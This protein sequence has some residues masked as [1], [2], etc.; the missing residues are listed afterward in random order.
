MK[1]GRRLWNYA[2]QYKKLLIWAVV[3]LIIA[4]GTELTGP[5]IGK[6]MID[7]H[8]L[9]IEKT[10]VKASADDPGA[11]RFRGH[12]YVR[13]DRLKPGADKTGEAHIY[14]VGA[15][16][17]FVDRPV[18]FD[19]NRSVSDGRLTISNG[20]ESRSYPAITLSRQE[21]FQFYRP[22][23]KGL[24]TLTAIYAGLLMFSVCF[25]YGQH[26]LLQM[27]ANRII[28]RMRQDVFSHIQKM[29]IRYFDNLPVGK[30][31]ARITN[32]TEAV[33]DLYVT[34]LSTFITSGV[35]M[36]GIF[37]ALFMLDVRL[38]AVCL[39]IIPILMIWSV[40]YRKY[41]SVFNQNIRSINSDINA[42]MNESIQGMPIIQAF[43]RE[44]ETMKEFEELNEAHFRYKNK[45]LSLNSLMS[46][47]LVN[48]LRNLAF[49][50]LIWY[51]GGASLSAAGIVS[52]GVLYAFVD[53]LNRLFQPVTGIVN[54]FSKLELARVSAARVF[55]L[56][57]EEG[58]EEEGA[59][60][61]RKAEGTVEFR[62]VSF[63]YRKGEEVLKHIS[64][65][66]E[67]GE[68]VALVGHTG[69]GKSSILNL[70]FRFYDAQKGDIL[71]DDKSIYGMSRQELRSH[72]GIVLQDPYL[73]SGTIGSNVTLDD[74]RISLEQAEEA[75]R[76]VGAASLLQSLPK[77]I[78]EPVTEKGGT[79]SSGQRQ[80]ISFARALV[81]DPAILI[82]DEATAHIDTET[83]A[84][85]QKALQVVQEGRTTFI[86]A[87]RLSTIRHA[88]Q[89]L[90][91][92]KGRIIEKGS[93]DELMAQKGQYHQMYELQKGT[94]KSA[95]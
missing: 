25:H 46:H 4:V 49:V 51:F 18:S 38:A 82:L 84:V 70:L 14:Q 86:I 13:E 8:I 30:V 35:Y 29:P 67:K 91:L 9:G 57:Q 90:V 16:Y 89:I 88:D 83:E 79:L 56:L 22:E 92:E 1:T 44:K 39:L 58:T 81:F 27:G 63:G 43:R 23:I 21:I 68:T 78:R 37:T 7:D 93:H 47:S 24:L 3:L 5:F 2:L 74:Q 11:V 60:A 69:S 52:I 95:V 53:Y 80:L 12:D 73:F 61:D 87:H 34:V 59:P 62:D 32:D 65:T 20:K 72:M 50:G 85:I 6:K 45:M 76:Q 36:L 41:A 54:Q 64:F 15:G 48:V 71:L 33:R 26:Y 75:L 31:V 10:W 66:A 55:E 28:Q 77:G 40:V 19:G 94:A 42:K 17:Y